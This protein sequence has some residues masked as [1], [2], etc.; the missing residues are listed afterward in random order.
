MLRI[1]KD[2]K[3]ITATNFGNERSSRYTFIR[4]IKSRP[5]ILIYPYTVEDIP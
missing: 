5:S 1:L 3:V 4:G 2:K